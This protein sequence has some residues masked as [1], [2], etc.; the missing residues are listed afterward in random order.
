MH[1]ES[2][3][4]RVTWEIGFQPLPPYTGT[5]FARRELIHSCHL[6]D[7]VSAFASI[8]GNSVCTTRVNPLVSPG[9]LG[10]S[11]CLHTRELRLHDESY[12]TRVTWGDW[13]SAFASI[14]GNSVCTT[15]VIPLVSPGRLGFSL[16][17]HTREL[18]LHDESYSTR[19]TWEI[20]F[21]PLPPYTGTPFARRESFHTCHLG[22]GV[23]AFASTHGNSVCTTR[24]IPLVSPGR[25]SFS[26]CLHTREL[27]L[28]DE[29]DS[30][31]V[32]WEIGFQPLP[33]Y[34][35]TPFARRELFHSCHLRDWVFSLCL[36]TRNSVCTTRVI[37]L[38]SPG[39]W[40][41]AF[42]SIHGNSVHSCHL[43]DWV[44]AFASIHGN[45]VCTTRVIPHVSP[46]RW[47]FSLCLHT[48]ELRLHDESYSTRITWE[49]EFQPLPP[50]T[51]TPFARRE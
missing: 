1:D 18:R 32:T 33:P 28:H 8:H 12:S 26:L 48:R 20:G 19:V 47:G 2:Y 29:S 45:S 49:I 24:V 16:C 37:P 15:R 34:T 30:T 21:Q 6:G 13:V 22:D 38:I 3:S 42:A 31:R 36:H 9:R 51:G 14:H 27:R 44:S 43:G 7:W 23:S 10:F 4:T 40:V 5:P 39:D 11:L 25:L 50:Y 35:G 46:G 17:L 41:S